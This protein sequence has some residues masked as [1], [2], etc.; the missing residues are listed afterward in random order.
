MC[1][2]DRIRQIRRNKGMTQA[3]LAKLLH[4]SQSTVYNYENNQREPSID[5]LKKIA[6]IGNVSLDWLIT[7]AETRISPEDKE[8]LDQLNSHPNL[9]RIV[10]GTI[11][12]A[13]E[14]K[15]QIEELKKYPDSGENLVTV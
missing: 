4:S 9:K 8:L 7:G 1:L 5:V 13:I 6:Q 11:E 15:Q 12:T 3:E 14:A 10:K 2:S